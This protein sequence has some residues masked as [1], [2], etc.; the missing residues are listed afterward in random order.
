[1]IYLIAHLTAASVY[2]AN[3][4]QV[5]KVQD[6]LEVVEP[7]FTVHFVK[8]FTGGCLLLIHYYYNGRNDPVCLRCLFAWIEREALMKK[9]ENK[10]DELQRIKDSLRREEKGLQDV[11]QK[12]YTYTYVHT[13]MCLIII[14]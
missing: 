11:I 12:V 1:M 5:A 2:F 10:Y 6:D 4:S 3:P 7:N 8:Y 14:Y 9:S 13:K